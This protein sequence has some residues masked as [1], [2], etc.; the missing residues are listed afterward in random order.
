MIEAKNLGMS[1]SSVLALKDVNFEI[2]KGEVIALLGPNG[3]GK[4]TILKILTTYIYP[5]YGTACISNMDVCQN[6]IAIRQLIGYLPEQLPL[7]M[8]ME[9]SEY[10][11]FVGKSRGLYGK[12]LQE[13]LQWV[14]E[15]CGLE[16][17]YH[18]LIRELSKG[19]RQRTALA[20]ALLH[21]P[22]IVILDE[23]T[24]GLDPYQIIEVRNLIQ[25]LASTKTIIF[26]THILQE[27]Q[28]VTS[29]IL[30]MNHGILVANGTL[31][32]LQDSIGYRKYHL[33][34]PQ[35]ISEN[36]VKAALETLPNI[37]TI[38]IQQ[39]R[40]EKEY[41]ITTK[42]KEDIISGINKIV[43]EKGWKF[44]ESKRHNFT[45]E[46]IFLHLTKSSKQ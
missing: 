44:I 3:A 41:S 21:D 10:L 13:R 23:P 22:Q 17:M 24:S 45:L 11:T 25:E 20:Q 28:A 46:E 26:S 42:N 27:V 18:K 14:K 39:N 16:I 40:D 29:K 33:V 37:G 4:S 7:Y 38:T 2:K 5:T 30:I 15:K 19:Y 31:E 12:K 6:P 43:Q 34:L 36:H 1:Y 35:N 8:D 9:V 32:Q